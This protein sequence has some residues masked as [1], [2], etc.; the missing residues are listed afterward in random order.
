MGHIWSGQVDAILAAG[1]SLDGAGV[2]NWA[3]AREDALLALKQLQQIGVA[4]LG[5]DV[6]AVSGNAVV[7]SYDNWHCDQG[8]GESAADFLNRSIDSARN[9]ISSYGSADALFAMVPLI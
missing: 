4:V 8:A 6:Y 3:L 1:R 2:R 7:L 5:G 9:Y